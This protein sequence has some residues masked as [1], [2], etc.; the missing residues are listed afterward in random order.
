M[1]STLLRQTRLYGNAVLGP[2]SVL[3]LASGIGM[4]SILGIPP[5][6]LWVRWGF[7]GI[8]GHFVLAA[9]VMRRATARLEALAA[10]GAQPEVLDG[11]RKRF[12]LL[13]AAYLLLLLS[14]VGAMA[15]KPQ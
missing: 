4:L 3:T 8:L 11:A 1:L 10:A 6:A 13:S 9:T 2:A 7:A 15:L 14:V 5:D 12:A